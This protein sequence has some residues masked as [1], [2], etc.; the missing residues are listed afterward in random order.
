M[1][2]LRAL[3]R[4]L[5]SVNHAGLAGALFFL[6]LLVR[7]EGTVGHLLLG[8]FYGIAVLGLIR[9]FRIRPW[10]YAVVGLITGPV[11]AALLFGANAAENEW[12]GIWLVSALFGLVVGLIECARVQ[13]LERE[14][15]RSDEV[16]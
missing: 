2:A 15:F 7:E 5:A 10:A 9:L 14:E 13:R 4:F 8:W 3:G 1:R 16:S 12:A 11:P 6:V